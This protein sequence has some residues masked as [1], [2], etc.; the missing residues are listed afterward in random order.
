MMSPC[1][2]PIVDSCEVHLAEMLF[3]FVH[4]PWL[5]NMMLPPLPLL[6]LLPAPVPPVVPPESIRHSL[7]AIASQLSPAPGCGG[8]ELLQAEHFDL[9]CLQ[10]SS[11]SRLP[12]PQD[13]STTQQ[14]LGQA[15]PV[16]FPL[17]CLRASCCIMLYS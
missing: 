8:I 9:H 3:F 2:A 6:L 16:V 13:N 1:I 10:V 11:R 17:P 15:A 12:S 4:L 5:M 14:H 7:H